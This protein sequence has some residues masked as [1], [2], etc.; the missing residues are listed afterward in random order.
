[1]IRAFADRHI[2]GQ[3]AASHFRFKPSARDIESAVA[4]IVKDRSEIG[5]LEVADRLA[6]KVAPLTI[7]TALCDLGWMWDGVMIDGDQLTERFVQRFQA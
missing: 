1:V 7:Y 3:A 4:A 6:V 2:D 5:F